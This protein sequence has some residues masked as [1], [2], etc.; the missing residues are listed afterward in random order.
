MFLL[1][2]FW[3]YYDYKVLQMESERLRSKYMVEYENLLLNEVGRIVTYI[4][5]EKSMTERRL[6]KSIRERTNE[7]Y[8]IATNLVRQNVGVIDDLTLRKLVKDSL[9]NIRFHNGRGYYFAFSMDGTEELFPTNPSL[10]GQNLLKMQDSQGTFVVKDMIQMIKSS[11]E[12]FYYYNWSK[13]DKPGNKYPKFAYIKYVPE[14][15][16]VIG[17]GDYLEEATLDLQEEICER[18]EQV[19][20]GKEQQEY[21]FAATWDGISKTFPAR[22]KNMLETKDANGVFVVKELIEKAKAGGGFVQYVMP[23]LE[24]THSA[25]KLS[26]A[27]PIPDWEWYIGAGVYIDE[28]D[29]HIANNHQLFKNKILE[30]LKIVTLVLICLLFINFFAA[31]F[32]S[33]KIW[34]QI[35]LFSNFFHRASTESISMDS[36]QLAY[37]EFREIGDLA[38]TMLVERNTILQE[39][40]VS[41]D[42][43]INTFNAIGDFILLL[44]PEGCVLRANEAANN[45]LG[46]A[47]DGAI[48][49]HYSSFCCDKS[50][51]NETLLDQ[52]PHS[53]EIENEKLGRQFHASSFPI[54]TPEGELHKIIYI[55]RDI[56]EQKRLKEQ[57]IQSQKMEAIGLL[58][59]GVAHD[60]NNILSGIV[61]YPDLILLQLPEGSQL[62]KQVI[63]I[64]QS[65]Q[66]AAEIVADLLTLARGI[67]ANKKVV[68]LNTLIVE[69][70]SS[71]E[72]EKLKESYPLISISTNFGVSLPYCSCSPVHIKKSLMNLL[73]NGAEAISGEGQIRLSTN[74]EY[75]AQKKAKELGIES[76]RY[77]MLKVE[78]TGSGIPASDIERIFEPFYTKKVMGKSGSGLGLAVVWNT[79]Q[80]HTGAIKVRS[81]VGSTEFTLYLPATEKTMQRDI[82]S[83]NPGELEGH[84]ET[85]LI[86]DDDQQQRDIALRFTREL[87]YK[88]EAVET[89][90]TAII[91]L[92]EKMVDL[93]ILDMILGTGMNGRE[94]YEKILQTHP[95]QKALVISGYSQDSE[96]QRTQQIGAGQYVKK[97]YT[98][99]QLGVAIKGILCGTEEQ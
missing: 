24:G 58:A 10:E 8:L 91:F 23:K 21:I 86:V 59:G 54:F 56:T 77:V 60:L 29:T 4:D 82:T 14:L 75:F 7:A 49:M 19:R 99:N 68:D 1:S 39:I 87:G 72:G 55:A 64:Q 45:I 11:G 52:R 92:A 93:V 79:I 74:N 34:K 25:P 48:G 2:G 88:A 42:E 83:L 80:D 38:N 98:I 84:G 63:A 44:D 51:I 62:R 17:T 9:R 28:I 18:I 37:K 27:A 16:W 5:Y 71:P 41:R 6:K 94:T 50:P 57:L 67:A 26:Y 36:E 15:D 3:I 13:P 81:S 70:L 95:G 53:A 69:H 43:W 47:P 30:H 46:V 97:P 33:R 32:I 90:E 22:D 89:G 20:F 65:G 35:D 96:V 78:D 61:S 12:G 85:I 66:R 73:I 40:S 76:G 31:Y